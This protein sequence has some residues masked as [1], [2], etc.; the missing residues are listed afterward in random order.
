MRACI[1]AC[2]RVSMYVYLE[3]TRHSGFDNLPH[4]PPSRALTHTHSQNKNTH[5]H[6]GSCTRLPPKTPRHPNTC[7]YAHIRTYKRACKH[8]YTHT[9]TYIH[10]QTL[11]P[12]NAPPSK[13]SETPEELAFRASLQLPCL[14]NVAMC[15]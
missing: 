12:L 5:R 13:D 11:R 8:T 1:N 15:R 10:N 4:H 6:Y 3:P 2:V 14:L 7:T 9:H